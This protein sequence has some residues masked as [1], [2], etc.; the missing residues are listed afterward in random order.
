MLSVV[1]LTGV[2][3]PGNTAFTPQCQP[4]F[5]PHKKQGTK[6]FTPQSRV[7]AFF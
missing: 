4:A 3:L 6:A 2:K 5:M 1:L 7:K